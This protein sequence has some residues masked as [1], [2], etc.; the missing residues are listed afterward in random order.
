MIAKILILVR[1]VF[2]VKR[3]RNLASVSILQLQHFYKQ[4]KAL[5]REFPHDWYLLNLKVKIT[6]FSFIGVQTFCIACQ[7]NFIKDLGM[8]NVL[9]MNC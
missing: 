3:K 5:F 6:S 1:V 4:V 2:E 8:I 9:V 7:D